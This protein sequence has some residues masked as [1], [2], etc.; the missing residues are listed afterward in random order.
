MM[1]MIPPSDMEKKRLMLLASNQGWDMD[2]SIAHH[3]VL[4]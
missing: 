2:G 3:H 4:G 1:D